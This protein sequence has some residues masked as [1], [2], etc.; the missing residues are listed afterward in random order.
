MSDTAALGELVERFL[1]LRRE[2]RAPDA[3]AFAAAHPGLVDLPRLLALADE[4]ERLTRPCAP[5][6]LPD[7]AGTDFRIIR[8]IA[9]RAIA[10]PRGYGLPDH[11]THRTRRHG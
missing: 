8:R 4:M 1:A 9:T 7:L 11:P 3:R 6:P 5:A 2:G 10:R